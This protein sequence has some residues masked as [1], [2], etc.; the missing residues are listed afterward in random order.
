M[1]IP[2]IRMATIP[3][4]VIEDDSAG[5]RRAVGPDTLSFPT[6]ANENQMKGRQ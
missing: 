1:R 3:A 6:C 5:L 2:G 4:G